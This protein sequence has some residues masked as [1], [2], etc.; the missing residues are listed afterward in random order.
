MTLPPVQPAGLPGSALLFSTVIGYAVSIADRSVVCDIESN[1]PVF[2]RMPDGRKVYDTR[3][4][5]DEREHAPQIV[6]MARQALEYARRRHLVWS[7]PGSE[8]LVVLAVSA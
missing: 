7:P 8:H 5:V 6:D 4:M 1:C 3:P 2:Y